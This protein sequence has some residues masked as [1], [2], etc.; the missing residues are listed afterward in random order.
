MANTSLIKV[1]VNKKNGATYSKTLLLN[2]NRVLDFERNT[3]TG[4]CDFYYDFGQFDLKNRA[5]LFACSAYTVNNLTWA[6]NRADTTQDRFYIHIEKIRQ[7][8]HSEIK[9][10]KMVKLYS[11]QIIFGYDHADGLG[12]YI[13]ITR[14]SDVYRIDTSHTLDDIIRAASKSASLSRS[15]M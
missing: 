8:G 9:K 14:G 7:T 1:A 13:W 15:P 6:I 2:T 4:L 5:V 3:S 12:C 11:D 10:D